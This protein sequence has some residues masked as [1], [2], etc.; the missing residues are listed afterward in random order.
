MVTDSLPAV[1]TILSTAPDAEVGERIV[2]KLLD[3][4]LIACGNI[5]PGVVSLYRWEGEVRKDA[6]VLI[7]MKSVKRLIPGLLERA[8]E[9]HPYEVP[10]LLVQ[11]VLT[12]APSYLDWVE[13]ECF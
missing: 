2:R 8:A 12:G 11:P 10:E 7:V 5:V 6:E 13:N 3:E 1:L 9:L 4:G